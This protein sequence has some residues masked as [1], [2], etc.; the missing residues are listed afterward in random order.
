MA[1]EKGT[2]GPTHEPGVRKG[3][4]II[5]QE[6]K[7]SGRHEKGQ[8]GADRPAGGSTAR[9]ST[10]VNPDDSNPIDPSSPKLPP[11]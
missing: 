3:E 2:S 7:E 11:A 9:D 5:E 6:G 1:D 8:T 10:R 4:E